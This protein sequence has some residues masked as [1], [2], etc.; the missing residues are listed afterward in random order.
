MDN[1][2]I[3]VGHHCDAQGY[4]FTCLIMQEDGSGGLC[5]YIKNGENHQNECPHNQLK[6]IELWHKRIKNWC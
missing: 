6:K 4:Y 1:S 2:I 5:P 3:P